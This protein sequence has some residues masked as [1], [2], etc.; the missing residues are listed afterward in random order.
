MMHKVF[1]YFRFIVYSVYF[2]DHIW[3]KFEHLQIHKE[4]KKNTH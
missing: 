1:I 3:D 2:T 4:P